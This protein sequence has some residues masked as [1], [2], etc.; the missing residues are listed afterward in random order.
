MAHACSSRPLLQRLD[1]EDQAAE[2]GCALSP[3][4]RPSER[5]LARL[6]LPIT[7][8]WAWIH[9]GPI[10]AQVTMVR[11]HGPQQGPA[12]WS[13]VAPTWPAWKGHAEF[14]LD[15]LLSQ[16]RPPGLVQPFRVPD[17][18][19]LPRCYLI[20]AAAWK[21]VGGP[22]V[23]WTLRPDGPRVAYLHEGIEPSAAAYDELTRG[24]DLIRG[25]IARRGRPPRIRAQHWRLVLAEAE[26]MAAAEPHLTRDQI[27][28]RINVPPRTLRTYYTWAEREQLA[29]PG[30][31]LL[32]GYEE[33]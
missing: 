6:G 17:Q 22:S 18:Y 23:F 16:Y 11:C 26:R 25:R 13:Q 27:A 5:L 10:G 31:R 12:Y 29:I 15:L 8:G 2:R 19:P 14:H 32:L 3:M 20:A 24:Y 1:H 28:A 4:C 33:G 9:A 21:T 7:A 30:P